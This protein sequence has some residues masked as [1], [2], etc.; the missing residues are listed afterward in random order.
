MVKAFFVGLA[1]LLSTILLGGQEAAADHNPQ[2]KLPNV[3][4]TVLIQ[5]VEKDAEVAWCVN[6]VGTNYPNFV[7]QLRQVNDAA[8]ARTGIAHRQVAWG[9]P[10]VTGCEVQHNA[11]WNH[12]CDGCA[13]WIMYAEWPV[14]VE[15]KI[16]LGYTDWRSTQAHEGTNCGH[17]MGEH[18]GYDD[19][20]FRSHKNTYGTWASPWNGPTV[21][22]VGTGVWECTEADYMVM[23]QWLTFWWVQAVDPCAS[24]GPNQDNLRWYPCKGGGVWE[25]P[26]GN[27]FY[28]P[29]GFWYYS[30]C[31]TDRLRWDNYA[32]EWKTPGS[33]SF[34]AEKGYWSVTPPC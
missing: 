21:M 13:A 7:S 3:P 18:E 28:P 6:D 5:N 27:T 15:Y 14:R 10:Q 32:G 9:T 12:S 26:D 1:L 22:D 20:N 33:A 30:A 16:S 25:T 31:N 34:R 2:G 4:W 23:A 8:Q 19:V 11:L 17:A 24:V 29:H